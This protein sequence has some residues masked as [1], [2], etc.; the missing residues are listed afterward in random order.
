MLR[1]FDRLVWLWRPIDAWLPWPSL[2]I[3]A[4]CIKPSS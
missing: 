1:L 2:S 3:I 4:V